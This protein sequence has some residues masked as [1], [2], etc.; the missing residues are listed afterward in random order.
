MAYHSNGGGYSGDERESRSGGDDRPE[1]D[2]TDKPIYLLEH[3]ATFTVNK[4]TGIVY[5]ADGM[6]RLLQLEKTTGIWSQKMQLCLD[7]QWVLIMDYETGN[8]IERFPATLIQEPTAFTSNDPM[9]MYNNILVFIVTGGSGSRSEMHIFQ[10]QGVS[11]V[12]LVEDLKKLRSGKLVTQH[13]ETI[14]I[15]PPQMKSSSLIQHRG[16]AGLNR[17]VIGGGESAVEHYGMSREL[18]S[19]VGGG[20]GGGVGGGGGHETDSELGCANDETSSTSSDKYE[21]DVTVLNHCFDDIEKFI[22]RLQHAA[23]ASR[24]LERRRRNRKSKKKDPGEGLLTLRT[25]PPHEK[26]FIDIFAKFKLSFNLLAKLKAHI[27]DPNAPE[28]VHFLFTPLA[29]IVEAS[30]DTYFES[31]LPVRVVNPLLTREAVN[32][33]INCVT[34]KETELWRSL[35]DA[36]T[37][38]RDQWKEDVGSYHPVFL[39]GWSPDYVVIDELDHMVTPSNTKRTIEHHNFGNASSL[40]MNGSGVLMS[41]DYDYDS[42]PHHH[43]HHQNQG[44]GG[45]SVDQERDRSDRDRERDMKDFSARSDI[46]LDSIERSGGVTTPSVGASLSNR[47]SSGHIGNG[48][49]A[50]LS[51]Q[52]AAQNAVMQS[53]TTGMQ[54]MYTSRLPPNSGSNTL[55]AG[56]AGNVEVSATRSGANGNSGGGSIGVGA[57]IT[58][59]VVSGGN[60]GGHGSNDQMIEAWLDELQATGAKIVLVTYPRTANNDKELSVVRGE[61][62][63]ILDDSRKWWKARNSR[64]QVAHV[65]HTIVTPFNNFNETE[66]NQF[67][68]HNYKTNNREAPETS[69]QLGGTTGPHTQ[70]SSEWVRNKHI[71]SLTDSSSGA[72][73]VKYAVPT[74]SRQFGHQHQQERPVYIPSATSSAIYSDIKAKQNTYN[75]NNIH[76][77]KH[78]YKFI[79]TIPMPPQPPPPPPPFLT[80]MS[81]AVGVGATLMP[82]L[83]SNLLAGQTNTI[84]TKSTNIAV[85]MQTPA[86]TSQNQSQQKH[87]VPLVASTDIMQEELKQVLRS[88]E[89]RDLDILK[90]P[91]IYIEQI[92][93]PSE[94][95]N[96]LRAKEFSE[97]IIKR[98]NHLSGEELFALPAEKMEELFGLKEGRRLASQI[99]LQKSVSGSSQSKLFGGL[100]VWNKKTLEGQCVV[101]NVKLLSLLNLLCNTTQTTSAQM[102]DACYGC[103]FRAGSVINGPTQL[104]SLNDCAKLYIANTDYGECARNLQSIVDGVRQTTDLNAPG[105]CYTGYCEFVRCIRRINSR[106]LIA[107]CYSEALGNRELGTTDVDRINFYTNVTSCILAKARCSQYNPISGE[108]QNQSYLKGWAGIGGKTISYFNSLQFSDAGDLRII[109]FPTVTNVGDLF[110]ARTPTLQQSGFGSFVC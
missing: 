28:L 79:S 5:P 96:W 81:T 16:G 64:G 18:S 76:Q 4:E 39:D 97:K 37:V 61:Y 14:N 93:S 19:I 86:P 27:H 88:R 15:A 3:L 47:P 42:P 75:N 30:S 95:E 57:V 24:E 31:Q 56:N 54:N 92:S 90:T 50:H 13:R 29:L 98:L 107:T 84:Y 8:I 21:R 12:H 9:E 32:L 83:N 59:S 103:F 65:P 73:P 49:Q 109:T 26:E 100:G 25:R 94:V 2:L 99:I 46:S 108:L 68:S 80:D 60:G 51:S 44:G 91:Q 10:S 69:S 22:A 78:Q 71:E 82:V 17:G 23:A 72:S 45:V 52:A 41:G 55:G 63:E 38:P 101:Q 34:S 77:N 87:Q 74:N 66:F 106:K 40:G 70:S 110:C 35:G 89:R 20:T 53:I 43:Q 62:L 67:Y 6:R 105:Y 11:A 48:T 36:W 102:R 1:N 33:L 58:G 104:T 7:Y 85:S